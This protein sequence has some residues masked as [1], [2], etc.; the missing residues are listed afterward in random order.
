MAN[1]LSQNE[2]DALMNALSRGEV[3]GRG[4][5]RTPKDVKVYDF[6]HPLAFL[7]EQL[8]TLEAIHE[9]LATYMTSSLSV[10]LQTAAQA[11]CIS[12]DQVSY[13]EF[14]Q[15]L[16]TPS[17]AFTIRIQPG[18]G[19]MLLVVQSSVVDAVLDRMAGGMG[20]P[21]TMDRPLTEIEEVLVGDFVGIIL[22]EMGPAWAKAQKL[23]F[24]QEGFESNAELCRV[25][26]TE[27]TV[28]AVSMELTVGET[29][30]LVNLCYP[31]DALRSFVDMLGSKSW[32]EES[33]RPQAGEERSNA[34]ALVGQI[35]LRVNVCLGKTTV[36]MQELLQ[37]KCGDVLILN[38]SIDQPVELE[39]S[40]RPRF[41]GHLGQSHGKKAVLVSERLM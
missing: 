37:L 24:V 26:R 8:R 38:R 30:G 16:P 19:R 17:P 27:N 15:S 5:G 7:K 36:A 33:G 11:K 3:Q 23:S 21:E 18:D 4:T 31:F 2:I 10:G 9:G 32:S 34:E 39:V 12:V 40:G 35:P 20:T 25:A 28:A 29:R 1:L 22:H 13:G 6:R 14:L 41:V